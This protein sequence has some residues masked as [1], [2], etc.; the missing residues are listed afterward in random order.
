VLRQTSFSF[1]EPVESA[2]PSIS[3]P[4]PA[5]LMAKRILRTLPP[6][7]GAGRTPPGPR[8][9]PRQKPAES[10]WI[11]TG[12]VRK[13]IRQLILGWDELKITW[14]AIAEK[15]PEKI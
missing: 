1:G 3:S 10:R 4:S 13:E 6:A 8:A 12:T 7:K 14:E 15:G 5:E 9:K 2:Y 11:I